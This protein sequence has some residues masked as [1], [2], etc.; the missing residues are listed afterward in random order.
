MYLDPGFGGMLVQVIIAIVAVGG[1][2]VYSFRRKIR[3]L[4]SKNGKDEVKAKASKKTKTSD[5][6]KVIDAIM[7][8]DS[9]DKN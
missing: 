4:F 6:G 5:N 7:D 2:F 8:D 3:T 1:G 9:D